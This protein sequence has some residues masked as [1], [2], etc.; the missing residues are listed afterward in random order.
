MRTRAR[1]THDAAYNSYRLV[2]RRTLPIT[3]PHHLARDQKDHH[4]HRPERTD[5]D[6]DPCAKCKSFRP[7]EGYFVGKD[8]EPVVEEQHYGMRAVALTSEHHSRTEQ[9]DSE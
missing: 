6:V 8:E 9:F 1:R 4:L 5:D 7:Y 3:Q 2:D